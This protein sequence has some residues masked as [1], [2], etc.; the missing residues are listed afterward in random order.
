MYYYSQ[1]T[2]GFYRSEIHGD[3]IPEDAVEITKECYTNL[4]LGQSQGKV[5]RADEHGKPFLADPDPPTERQI[6]EAKVATCKEYLS[7]TDYITAKYI[8]LV[9]ISKQLSE[10]AFNDKYDEVLVKR[11]EARQYIS[12]NPLN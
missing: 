9:V 1:D 5:I 3:S 10:S 2:K 11:Q 8:E 12:N 4:L 6:I 7:S